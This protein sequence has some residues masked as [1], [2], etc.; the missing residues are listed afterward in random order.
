LE[1]LQTDYI[2][3]MMM[4]MPEKTD[5]LKLEGFHAAMQELKAEGRVRFVG[6]SHHGS[7]WFADPAETMENVLLAA[8]DDGR[9]DVFLM[10]Y[11]SPM[12]GSKRSGR[13]YGKTIGV[14]DED[15]PR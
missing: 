1:E 9:F 14:A 3:C 7:F 2:D 11:N 5:T 13:L 6:V 10:A 8:A 15:G 4:H 12:D